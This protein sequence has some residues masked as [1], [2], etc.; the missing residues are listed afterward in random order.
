MCSALAVSMMPREYLFEKV[1]CFPGVCLKIAYGFRLFFEFM[2]I[3]VVGLVLCYFL[4]I[5]DPEASLNGINKLIQ[6]YYEK[7]DF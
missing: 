3:F 1:L 5:F 4:F 2:V 6:H 7:K